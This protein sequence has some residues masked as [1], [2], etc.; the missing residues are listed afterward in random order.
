MTTIESVVL[1]CPNCGAPLPPAAAR[2][3][4]TCAFCHVTSVAAPRAPAGRSASGQALATSPAAS[5]NLVCP[6][7]SVPLFEGRAKDVVLEGCGQCGG[8]WLDNQSAQR[9]MASPESADVTALA[10]RAGGRAH[11]PTSTRAI[12]NCPVCRAGLPRVQFANAGVEL[13][14]CAEHGTWFD[15]YELGLVL[16]AMHKKRFNTPTI[17]NIDT[18]PIPDFRAGTG[19]DATGAALV[20]G[21]VFTLL[22]AVLSIGDAK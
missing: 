14:V 3:A 8:I 2:E 11:G 9:A 17:M 6:R 12:A 5:T 1:A 16:G 7:C 21:G 19:L 15:R 18:G 13:D 22:G 20:V 10:D 4:V